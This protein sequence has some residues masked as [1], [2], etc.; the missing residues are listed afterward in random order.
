MW[1]RTNMTQSN[2]R[3]MKKSKTKHESCFKQKIYIII[4]RYECIHLVKTFIWAHS[5]H[6]LHFQEKCFSMQWILQMN[7]KSMNAQACWNNSKPWKFN[8]TPT[9]LELNHQQ[10][11]I[12]SYL[13]ELSS[14]N[15]PK[16]AS[17]S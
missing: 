11:W 8:Q 9:K 2:L 14:L 7:S 5:R 13:R 1:T 16:Q 15:E 6:Q 10:S 4:Q 3:F 17:W 12:C